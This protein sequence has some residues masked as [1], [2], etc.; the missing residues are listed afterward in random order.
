MNALI[1]YLCIIMLNVA[2]CRYKRLN[3]GR[4]DIHDFMCI[5]LS[6]IGACVIL[7]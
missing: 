4:Y 2:N 5:V 3:Y 1:P 7:L 6:I